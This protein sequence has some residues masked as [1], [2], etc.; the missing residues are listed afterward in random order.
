PLLSYY[1]EDFEPWQLLTSIQGS[2]QWAISRDIKQRRVEYILLSFAVADGGCGN[3]DSAVRAT[4]A[5]CVHDIDLRVL[6][7]IISDGGY[8]LIARIPY[9]TTSFKSDYMLWARAGPQR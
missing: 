9:Q 6:S 1:A 3:A 5:Q 8:R 2:S 4:Q 7:Q